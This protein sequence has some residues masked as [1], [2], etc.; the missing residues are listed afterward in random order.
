MLP[1]VMRHA[2][3]LARR[4]QPEVC[5]WIIEKL[6][7]AVSWAVPQRAVREALDAYDREYDRCTFM[8]P[9]F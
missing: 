8:S 3:A 2:H 7:E 9:L 4:A 1:L 6:G 5:R